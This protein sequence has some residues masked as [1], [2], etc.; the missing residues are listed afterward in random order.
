MD[1]TAT[2]SGAIS[3]QTEFPTEGRYRLF[4]QF[5]DEGEVHTAD[6]TLGVD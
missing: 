1:V 4:L 3:F 2:R 5:N 6:F